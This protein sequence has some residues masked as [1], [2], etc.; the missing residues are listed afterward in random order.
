MLEMLRE[1]LNH[2]DRIPHPAHSL[3]LSG[4]VRHIVAHYKK[5]PEYVFFAP[6]SVPTT[7]AV[8]SPSALTQ[9][10]QQSRDFAIWGSHVVEMPA[11][12]HTQF[13]AKL[14]PLSNKAH[15]RSCP[16]RVVT[17]AD[18]IK[19]SRSGVFSTCLCRV[20][21][22]SRSS[23]A[24]ATRC[25]SSCWRTAGTC[26]SDSR[27]CSLI[28]AWRGTEL[29]RRRAWKG[30]GCTVH[31]RRVA[32]WAGRAAAPG[33]QQL[34]LRHGGHVRRQYGFAAR[35]SSLCSRHGLSDGC[36]IRRCTVASVVRLSLS[37]RP[38]YRTIKGA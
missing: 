12:L 38:A 21:A 36:R 34:R 13:C 28:A 27:R 1:A 33:H 32:S 25:M 24:T 16:E 20:G 14:W 17:M 2:H 37:L 7:S 9:T 18:A 31:A 11:S 10:A 22:R 4:W 35:C 3:P 30:C 5:L 23:S 8:F 29:R 26:S 6:A 19:W 15:K